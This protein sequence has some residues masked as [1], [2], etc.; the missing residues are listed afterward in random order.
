[1]KPILIYNHATDTIR[2][3][4]QNYLIA[5]RV[6]AKGYQRWVCDPDI[7]ADKELATKVFIALFDFNT[8]YGDGLN[9][10]S[11]V[12]PNNSDVAEDLIAVMDSCV[13]GYTGEW[14][15]T[16]EGK[17]GF[18]DMYTILQRVADH[19]GIDTSNALRFTQE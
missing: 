11:K 8:R 18:G 10:L 19:F 5:G 6:G 13:E 17:D 4:P 3:M 14:D 16:G 12:T 9:L 1:M 7:A 2:Q 15:S